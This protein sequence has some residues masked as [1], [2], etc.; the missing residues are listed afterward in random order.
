MIVHERNQDLMLKLIGQH[1]Q[2]RRKPSGMLVPRM[3]N[4]HGDMRRGEPNNEPRSPSR[5]GS[6]SE[7]HNGYHM[8]H[9]NRSRSYGGGASNYYD[10][11]FN[12]H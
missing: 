7:L 10:R 2:Y 9:H 3:S 8:T 12:H 6:D 5:H 1:D 4:F 11:Q